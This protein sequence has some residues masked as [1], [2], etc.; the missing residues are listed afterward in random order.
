LD[1]ESNLGRPFRWPKAGD[2]LFAP[3]APWHGNAV[4]A[5]HAHSRLVLMMRDHGSEDQTAGRA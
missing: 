3:A 2:K 5:R 1:F 4:I